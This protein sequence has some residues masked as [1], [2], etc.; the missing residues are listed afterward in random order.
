[1]H[2]YS[3]QEASLDNPLSQWDAGGDAIRRLHPRTV[4]ISRPSRATS[5]VVREGDDL[6]RMDGK[7]A[8]D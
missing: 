3:V 4:I 8:D 5:Y 6:S 2:L 7:A 1:M